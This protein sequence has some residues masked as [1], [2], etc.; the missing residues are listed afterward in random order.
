[1]SQ[2]G[3]VAGPIPAVAALILAGGASRRFGSDK[4]AARIG[5]TTMLDHLLDAL[6]P[7]W[8]IVAVGPRRQT[9]R[10][11]T[12]VRERPPGGGPL[13]AIEAG[14]AAVDEPL[15][16]VVAGDMPDAARAIP[17]LVDALHAA[18]AETV[19]AIGVDPTGV[20]N[21]LLAAYRSRSLRERMPHPCADRPARM[22]LDLPHVLVRADPLALRDVDVPSDLDR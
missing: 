22:L 16:V 7:A 18:P 11:V 13:A 4:L 2:T 21:P 3:P 14:V 1:V 20:A 5:A 17:D 6:P 10:P 8:R 12:W 19:G 9:S 15:V